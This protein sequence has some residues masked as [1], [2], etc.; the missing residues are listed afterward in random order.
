MKEPKLNFAGD[1]RILSDKE[2]HTGS[3]ATYCPR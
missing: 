3:V 1:V 2:Y